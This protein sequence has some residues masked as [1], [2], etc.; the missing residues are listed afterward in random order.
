MCIKKKLINARNL[1][2][3]EFF[4]LQITNVKF[5]YNHIDNINKLII[6]NSYINLLFTVLKN[7]TQTTFFSIVDYSVVSANNKYAVYVAQSFFKNIKLNIFIDVKNQL[8]SLTNL[9][10]GNMWI[11]RELKEFSN[12][13]VLN[14]YDTRKLLLNYDYNTSITYNSFN[15]I[16]TDISC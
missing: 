1:W 9:Y 7:S 10:Y 2:W 14:L 16:I 3:I 12:I 13:Y 8:L 15:N 11:E 4:S 5:T 6:S